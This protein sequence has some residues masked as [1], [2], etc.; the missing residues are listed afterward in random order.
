MRDLKTAQHFNLRNEA[1]SL[2]VD[3]AGRKRKRK[4]K[5]LRIALPE[6]N[7]PEANARIHS[8]FPI[9][10]TLTQKLG[11]SKC[12]LNRKE[13]PVLQQFDNFSASSQHWHSSELSGLSHQHRRPYLL[14]F[15]I[16]I[17]LIVGAGIR[18]FLHSFD[19]LPAHVKCPTALSLDHTLNI[20]SKLIY[21]YMQTIIR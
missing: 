21:W 15:F 9:R 5:L 10:A 20:F 18:S 3:S 17:P 8:K 14:L 6:L 2:G 16:P 7:H 1:I 12:T 19:F 4:R 11:R 13:S